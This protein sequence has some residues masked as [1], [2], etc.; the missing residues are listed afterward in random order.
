MIAFPISIAG[1]RLAAIPID[2]DEFFGNHYWLFLMIGLL[3]LAQ[4][5][6]VFP[7]NEPCKPGHFAIH[8]KGN[9]IFLLCDL[10]M[11]VVNISVGHLVFA[12]SLKHKND[13][14]FRLPATMPVTLQIF[15][16]S[17]GYSK[18]HEKNIALRGNKHLGV[19]IG[20]VKTAITC[21]V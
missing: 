7:Y 17:G 11:L 12:S 21:C 6:G 18:S 15:Y 1:H 4:W 9:Y 10:C 16:I 8:F 13:D 3:A 20:Q 5:L 14:L 2:S 19:Y